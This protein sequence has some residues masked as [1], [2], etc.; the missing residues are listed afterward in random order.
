MRIVPNR[1]SVIIAVCLL[2]FTSIA[3]PINP[4]PPPTGP[5]PPP[6]SPIDGGVFLL[7]IISLLYG[8]YKVYQYNI[9]KNA[10]N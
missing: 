1:I 7:F 5:P 2:S 4:P 6:G 10:A 8:L 3:A 9:K